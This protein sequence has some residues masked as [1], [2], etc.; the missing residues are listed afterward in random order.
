VARAKDG[1]GDYPDH[2][3]ADEKSDCCD[4]D[5]GHDGLLRFRP[6]EFP[7]PDPLPATRAP[8]GAPAR[9][10]LV[11]HGVPVCPRSEL[12]VRYVQLSLTV[13]LFGAIWEILVHPSSWTARIDPMH[14]AIPTFGTCQGV[15]T[16]RLG[17]NQLM[18]NI[19]L[20]R[21]ARM[22]PIGRAIQANS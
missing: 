4:D 20:S 16:A 9:P 5:T 15:T 6:A 3:S 11:G 14:P 17:I 13:L 22:I 19:L 21:M 1:H 7:P 18:P 8:R 2:D 10:M 12:D